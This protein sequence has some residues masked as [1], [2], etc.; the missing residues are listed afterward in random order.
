MLYFVE[1]K[2]SPA[3]PSFSRSSGFSVTM[4]G[5]T[6]MPTESQIRSA[7]GVPTSEPYYG[8]GI[9]AVV[10]YTTS[11]S[12]GSTKIKLETGGYGGTWTTI[13]DIPLSVTTSQK[14]D[15]IFYYEKDS[16]KTFLQRNTW[17][18]SFGDTLHITGSIW[19]G[20]AEGSFDYLR[21][22]FVFG[23]PGGASVKKG[24]PIKAS[25]FTPLGLS[26]TIG[27]PIKNS[28]FTTGTVITA[29]E[30]NAKFPPEKHTII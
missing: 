30:F 5:G 26:A 6:T 18:N 9:A 22:V 10:K 25:D 2:S 28:S 1:Y 20:R 3:T 23:S 24:D 16:S 27:N 12:S 4:W 15:T 7:G 21:V 11:N 13:Y 14:T 19:N 8:I 17:L 29:D